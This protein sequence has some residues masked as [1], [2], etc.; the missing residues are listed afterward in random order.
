MTLQCVYNIIKYYQSINEER[1]ILTNCGVRELDRKGFT[2]I[3]LAVVLVV[4]GFVMVSGVSYLSLTARQRAVG[5]TSEKL[6]SAD[7]SLRGFSAL[8]GR[9]PAGDEFASSVSQFSDFSGR[10]FRYIA[11]EELT[12]ETPEFPVCRRRSTGLTVYRCKNAGCTD[13]E[14]VE[15][16]AYAVISGGADA[17]IETEADENGIIRIHAQGSGD[18]YDDSAVWASLAEL[19]AYSDCAPYRLRILNSELPYAD[20]G[21]SY[22]A[23]VFADG[24]VPFGSAY[25]WCVTENPFTA[26]STSPF[27][28]NVEGVQVKISHDCKSEPESDWT[29]GDNLTIGGT[30][31]SGDAGTY[32]AHFWVRD[33]NNE[34]G[35]DD[36][37]A[38]R[39]LVIST[40]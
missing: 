35:S 1:L 16:A 22:R 14:T 12:A 10:S 3:E 4:L 20:G 39:K 27:Y 28:L 5:M 13:Y 19:Q 21:E 34:D 15:N 18:D 38:N 32:E 9:L 26:P 36:S 31:S 24:G 17:E 23:T 37:I 6:E 11:A 30:P 25:R 7:K 40:Y 2:L 29:L 8:N 33:N